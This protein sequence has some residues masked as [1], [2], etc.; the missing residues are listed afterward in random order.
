[1]MHDPTEKEMDLARKYLRG[2]Y[3]EVQFNYWAVQY[4]SDRER[5]ERAMERISSEMPLAFA[6]KFILLCMLLH[7]MA[8]TAYSLVSF[9]L[10]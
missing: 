7:F 4:G 2:E 5:M 3:T 1:M 10:E 6:A 9:F 8:C